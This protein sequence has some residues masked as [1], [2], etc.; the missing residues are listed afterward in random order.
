MASADVDV[1][2][3]EN[4][5]KLRECLDRHVRIGLSDGR[6]VV[7]R[8]RCADEYAN[9]VLAEAH[10]LREIIDETYKQPLSKLCRL[11]SFERCS[12]RG[13]LCFVVVLSCA[14]F[15]AVNRRT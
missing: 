12:L 14:L 15:V 2:E 5:S 7:G 6:V 1:V 4:L 10:E 3:G 11:F 13:V 9:I 8:F